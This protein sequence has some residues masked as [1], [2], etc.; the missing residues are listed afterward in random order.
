MEVFR[1]WDIN[2]TQCCG[3]NCFP[4]QNFSKLY[5]FFFSF[6]MLQGLFTTTFYQYVECFS[7]YLMLHSHKKFCPSSNSAAGQTQPVWFNSAF[8]ILEKH[9]QAAELTYETEPSAFH[10]SKWE[11]CHNHNSPVLHTPQIV[12]FQRLLISLTHNI[13]GACLTETA[14]VLQTLKKRVLILHP[15][16]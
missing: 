12:G 10:N 1:I 3:C 16:T 7:V 9:Q 13:R 4:T 14:F 11:I 2:L 6:S 5:C 8:T 15:N